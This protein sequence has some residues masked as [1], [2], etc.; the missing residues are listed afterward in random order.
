MSG[1]EAIALALGLFPLVLDGVTNYASVAGK[2]KQMR[3]HKNTLNELKRELE[4]EGAI[5]ENTWN[6]LRIR[7]GVKV[8]LNMDPSKETLEAVLSC[9]PPRAVNSFLNG[10]QELSEILKKL[11]TNFEKYEQNVVGIDYVLTWLYH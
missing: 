11:N 2:V 3:N 7:S 10:C 4:M 5:F 1:I 9:L 8:E 6:T